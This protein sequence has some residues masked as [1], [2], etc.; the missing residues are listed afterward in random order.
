MNELE[1]EIGCQLTKFI[2]A[3][4]DIRKMSEKRILHLTLKKNWFDLIASGVKKEEYREIKPFW[5]VRLLVKYTY[6]GM[7]PLIYNPAT[8][9]YKEYD[10]IHFRNGY[11]KNAPLLVVEWKGCDIGPAVPEWSDNWPGNVFRI[12]LG[13]ILSK[14]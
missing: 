13:K 1:K 3:D 2:V 6:K 11:G 4:K 5:A 14:S 12:K 9:R 7:W 10:E 8:F